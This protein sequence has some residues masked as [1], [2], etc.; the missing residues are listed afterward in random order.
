MG[1]YQ[2]AIAAN[3]SYMPSLIGLAD[4]LWESGAHAEAKT[5]YKELID[6][7]P[8]GMIPDRAR[9]RSAD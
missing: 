9:E 7:F 3:P 5:R 6:R 1:L 2:K 4:A 8:P